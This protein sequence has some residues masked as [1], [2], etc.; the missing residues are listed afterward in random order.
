[1][2][3]IAK[4]SDPKRLNE[5]KQKIDDEQYLAIAIKQIAATLTHE[6]VNINEEKA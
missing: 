1:M 5:L 4:Q 3:R 2:I 6:I